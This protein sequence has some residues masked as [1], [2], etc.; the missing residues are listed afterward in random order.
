MARHVR[1]ARFLHRLGPQL[2]TPLVDVFLFGG[3][4]FH[5]AYLAPLS[6]STY[7][8]VADA[9]VYA[10]AAQHALAGQGLYPLAG[11]GDLRTPDG[12]YLPFLYPPPFAAALA[13]LGFLSRFVLVRLFKAVALLAFWAYA[14]LLCL[15]ATGR[16]SFR[17]VLAAGLAVTLTPGA[18]FNLVSGQ[19][20]PTLWLAFALAVSTRATGAWLAATCLVKPFGAWPLLL[21]L[22]REPRRVLLPAALVAVGGLLLGGLVCG[23]E[24]YAQWLH[25]TPQRMYRVI[26][27][28][29]NASLS[30]LPLRALGYTEL[31]P[32]GRGYLLA[33]YAVVPGLVAFTQRRRPLALQ[34]SWVAV[35]AVLFTPFS[36]LY[37]LPLILAPLALEWR[38]LLR[39]AEETSAGQCMEAAKAE[40]SGEARAE[41]DDR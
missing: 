26:F 38:G 17:G 16:L 4:A 25:Y 33:L 36:R 28:E 29:H 10:V 3:L 9:D 5:L 8:P 23:W 24:A 12:R 2:R 37:Y 20:E 31:P 19:I 7:Y 22:W 21:A 40:R 32:W 27:F 11:G 30:L 6:F 15:L 1:C 35:A 18:L 13:P 34:Y 14:L 41:G 39:A